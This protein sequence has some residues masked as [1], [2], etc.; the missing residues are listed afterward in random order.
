[1][2]ALYSP[3]SGAQ[4]SE[5]SDVAPGADAETVNGPTPVA[6]RD[7]AL[8]PLRFVPWQALSIP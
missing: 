3:L 4:E 2:D 7:A 1:M 8:R 6:S 5:K